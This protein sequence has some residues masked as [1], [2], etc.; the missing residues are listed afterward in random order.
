LWVGNLWS[1][2]F[3][4]VFAWACLAAARRRPLFLLYALPTLVM[5]GLHAAVANHYSRYNL[6]L[7]GP[8]S[9][10]AAWIIAGAVPL[11]FARKSRQQV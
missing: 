9:A 5:V 6:I 3:I 7:I 11:V 8:A 1:L 2:V 10:G 4:P